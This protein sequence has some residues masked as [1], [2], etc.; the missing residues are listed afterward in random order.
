M[1]ENV[2]I[3]VNNQ[4]NEDEVAIYSNVFFNGGRGSILAK[5]SNKLYIGNIYIK[6]ITM[7]K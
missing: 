7:C 1:L 6:L 2:R 5:Q 4:Q 3:E